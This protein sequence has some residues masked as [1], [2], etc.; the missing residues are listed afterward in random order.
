MKLVNVQ[1]NLENRAEYRVMREAFN[2]Y[3][4]YMNQQ[5]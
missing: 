2:Q 5:N 3:W 1:Q 4:T